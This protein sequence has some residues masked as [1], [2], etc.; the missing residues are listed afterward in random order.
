MNSY[1]LFSSFI[2]Y[3]FVSVLDLVCSFRVT[4]QHFFHSSTAAKGSFVTS[5][6]KGETAGWVSD[7]ESKFS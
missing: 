6:V 1:T 7:S 3:I 4:V 5:E 2:L